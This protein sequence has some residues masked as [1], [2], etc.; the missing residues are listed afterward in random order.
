MSLGPYFFFP[1]MIDIK[2]ADDYVCIFLLYQKKV[3]D[4]V[5]Q[6]QIDR[7]LRLIDS[8]V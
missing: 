2:K 1:Q 4:P 6:K 5:W 7:V 8:T 3:E